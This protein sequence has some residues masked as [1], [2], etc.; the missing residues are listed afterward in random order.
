MYTGDIYSRG[1]DYFVVCFVLFYFVLFC[2]LENPVIKAYQFQWVEQ[3]CH[4]RKSL[5]VKGTPDE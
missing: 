1:L 3:L 5:A 2:L 4:L